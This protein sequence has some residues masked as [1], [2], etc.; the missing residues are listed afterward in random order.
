MKEYLQNVIP[1]VTEAGAR[2]ERS[3]DIYSLLLKERIVFLGLPPPGGNLLRGDPFCGDKCGAPFQKTAVG[4]HLAYIVRRKFDD[5][6]PAVRQMLDES[7]GDEFFECLAHR[8]LAHAEFLRQTFLAQ[9]L[10]G[11]EVACLNRRAQLVGDGMVELFVG[12][13]TGHRR[14]RSFDF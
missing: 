7:F 9:P 1:M 5:A 14:Q 3:V 12:L 4:V 2:G 6:H 11:L 10:A 13:R 8:H